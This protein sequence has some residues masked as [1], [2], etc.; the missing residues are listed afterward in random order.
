M[1]ELSKSLGF[2]P[3]SRYVPNLIFYMAER[4]FAYWL[5]DSFISLLWLVGFQDSEHSW[6]LRCK[7]SYPT[8]RSRIFPWCLFQCKWQ[9]LKK[10]SLL[11]K[12]RIHVWLLYFVSSH[13]L[14]VNFIRTYLYYVGAVWTRTISWFNI[15]YETTK[16]CASHLCVGKDRAYW[17]QGDLWFLFSFNIWIFDAV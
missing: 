17:S 3:N 11:L 13:A 14:N 5:L 8:W 9:F 10:A 16:N 7:I 1:H 6:F 15:S 12:F 4:T 2:L